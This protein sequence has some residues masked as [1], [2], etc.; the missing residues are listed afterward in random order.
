MIIYELI[1]IKIYQDLFF[2]ENRKSVSISSSIDSGLNSPELENSKKTCKQVN[3]PF[4]VQDEIPSGHS[5][6]KNSNCEI[7]GNQCRRERALSFQ[8]DINRLMVTGDNNVIFD[9]N[10]MC[11]GQIDYKLNLGKLYQL[12]FISVT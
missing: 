3:D 9:T 6:F 11:S 12:Q 8:E 1:Q 10:F 2:T 7:K 4:S 5:F